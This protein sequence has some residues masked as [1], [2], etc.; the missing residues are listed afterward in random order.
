MTKLT[1]MV[2]NLGGKNVEILGMN[3]GS[4]CDDGQRHLN[5]TAL[6]ERPIK[7]E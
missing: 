6:L 3:A 1:R 4:R 7:W 2:F 5:Q